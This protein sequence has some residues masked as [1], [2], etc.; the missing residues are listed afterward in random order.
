MVYPKNKK[1]ILIG[2]GK[3]LLRGQTR[4]SDSYFLAGKLT[5]FGYLVERMLII[6]DEE[7]VIV[8]E[9]RDALSRKPAMIFTTGGLGPTFDDMTVACVAKGLRRKLRLH[10]EALKEVQNYYREMKRKGVV[11]SATITPAR[12]KM[13][14]LPQGASPLLNPIGGA[15]AV[16]IQSGQTKIFLLPGVPPEMKSIYRHG[17]EPLLRKSGGKEYRRDVVLQTRDESIVAPLAGKIMAQF[18][19]VY[20]KSHVRGTKEKIRVT[21]TLHGFDQQKLVRAAKAFSKLSKSL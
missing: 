2:I 16:F 13:A 11:D 10:P 17:I 18:P 15:P 8:R 4:D 14:M 3:E 12:K 21:V 5:R 7:K 20:F 9:I 6:D 19:G 1:V